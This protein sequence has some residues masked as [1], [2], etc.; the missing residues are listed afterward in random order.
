MRHVGVELAKEAGDLQKKVPR[1]ARAV[2]LPQAP[3]Q[4]R[5]EF[6][7]DI[8]EAFKKVD[9]LGLCSPVKHGGSSA[10]LLAS[11]LAA[12]HLLAFAPSASRR[13]S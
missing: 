1:R 9:L 8:V 13:A 4:A 10:G 5:R 3:R 6:R 12:G 2:R 11:T 7:E